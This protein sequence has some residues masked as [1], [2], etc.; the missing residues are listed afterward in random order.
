MPAAA[1][2]E[3]VK[4]FPNFSISL[5]SREPGPVH[6]PLIGYPMAPIPASR[7]YGRAGVLLTHSTASL[8][9]IEYPWPNQYHK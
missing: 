1:T 5:R 2:A 9:L 7:L 4:R 3:S 6:R 8:F